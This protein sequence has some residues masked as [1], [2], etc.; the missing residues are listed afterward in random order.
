M[1]FAVDSYN[2]ES[3]GKSEED[4]LRRLRD[5]VRRADARGSYYIEP[6]WRINEVSTSRNPSPYT[7]GTATSSS[8]ETPPPPARP[9]V[10]RTTT[11]TTFK[12]HIRSLSCSELREV[13]MNLCL[14]NLETHREVVEILKRMQRKRPRPIS[15]RERVQN[16][17]AGLYLY[18][19]TQRELVDIVLEVTRH[20]GTGYLRQ[21][22][23]DLVMVIRERK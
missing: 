12:Q 20:D 15:L 21:D 14:K 22:V 2:G 7:T 8:S 3:S 4:I 19:R 6:T 17:T 18:C 5:I 11:T 10:S 1:A 16:P 23:R 9:R 13:I